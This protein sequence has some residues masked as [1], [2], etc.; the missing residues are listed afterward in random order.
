MSGERPAAVASVNRLAGVTS[1]D[2]PGDDRFRAGSRGDRGVRARPDDGLRGPAQW[3]PGSRRMDPGNRRRGGWSGAGLGPYRRAAAVGLVPAPR[4]L[5]GAHAARPPETG[6]RR[7]DPLCAAPRAGGAAA[8]RRAA[9]A[10]RREAGWGLAATRAIAGD[11]GT[12]DP[13]VAA[14]PGGRAR[15]SERSWTR[16]TPRRVGAGADVDSGRG[17]ASRS[18]ALEPHRHLLLAEGR[19]RGRWH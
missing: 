15:R 2:R 13:A 3:P 9:G 4:P 17:C 11:G 8:P 6:A 10:P 19:D 14:A 12:A 16:T 7:G 18:A 5:R 1:G